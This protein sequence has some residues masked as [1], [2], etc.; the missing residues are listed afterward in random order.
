MR[1][2][3]FVC[4]FVCLFVC[5]VLSSCAVSARRRCRYSCYSCAALRCAALRCYM[6]A[7]LRRTS[8]AASSRPPPRPT[9]RAPRRCSTPC[10]SEVRSA[11]RNDRFHQ[12]YSCVDGKAQLAT[13]TLSPYLQPCDSFRRPYYL[14]FRRHGGATVAVAAHSLAP[15]QLSPCAARVEAHRSWS[16]CSC[17]CARRRTPAP[18]P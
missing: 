4:L 12:C 5:W 9:E 1:L 6:S 16:M 7:L 8:C 17:L 2:G 3:P 10:G 18:P 14:L 13:R 15:S 11:H